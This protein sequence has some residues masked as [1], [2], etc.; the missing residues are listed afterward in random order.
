MQGA[1]GI[2][3]PRRRAIGNTGPKGVLADYAE[4][5]ELQRVDRELK[6]LK[7]EWMLKQMVITANNNDEKGE[8]EMEAEEKE[9]VHENEIEDLEDEEL[10]EEYK[11]QRMKEIR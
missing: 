8:N 7:T 6:N 9:R 10:F 5:V 11:K 1:S 4:H 3:P 2:Q